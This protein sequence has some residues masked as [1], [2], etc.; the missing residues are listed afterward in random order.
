MTRSKAIA[1]ARETARN[2][3]EGKIVYA[4]CIL[5]SDGSQT[6]YYHT[7]FSVFRKRLE[8]AVYMG[9]KVLWS[10]YYFIEE[11]L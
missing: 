11:D 4:T 7:D 9:A 6:T 8:F 5:Y 1:A 3:V 2:L 10:H